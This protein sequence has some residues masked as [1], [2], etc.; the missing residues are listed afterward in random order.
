MTG[1]DGLRRF[2]ASVWDRFFEFITPSDEG[3]SR[4]EVQE[5]LRRAGIDVSRAVAK[6]N[7]VLEFQEARRALVTAGSRHESAELHGYQ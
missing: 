3:L 1:N 5:E 2:D 7:E 4:G 6:V